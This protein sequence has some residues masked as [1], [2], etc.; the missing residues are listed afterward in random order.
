LCAGERAPDISGHCACYG[1]QEALYALATV[2]SVSGS[3]IAVA[4]E[5]RWQ[6]ISG[7]IGPQNESQ[8]DFAAPA[9]QDARPPAMKWIDWDDLYSV[10]KKQ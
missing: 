4:I 5:G 10:L 1:S 3:Q 7:H 8:Q 9:E 6:L 2:T